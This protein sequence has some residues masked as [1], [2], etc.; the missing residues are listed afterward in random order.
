MKLNTRRSKKAT[1]QFQEVFGRQELIN[2]MCQIYS[3]GK[4]GLDAFLLETGKM[5]AETIMYIDREE[6]SRPDYRPCTNKGG[7]VN[8]Y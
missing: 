3:K 8:Y 5:M 2:R 6:T 7:A 1:K 4:Q